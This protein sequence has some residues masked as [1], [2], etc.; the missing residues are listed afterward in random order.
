MTTIRKGHR[1]AFS[2]DFLRSTGQF[3][4]PDN[5]TSR[6]PFARGTVVEMLPSPP[7]AVIRWDDDNVSRVLAANLVRLDRLH[8]EM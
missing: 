1:V 7:L 2:R 4:G 8:L 3:T 6:G 5:P